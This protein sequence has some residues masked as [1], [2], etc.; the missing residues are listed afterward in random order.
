MEGRKASLTTL[1]STG[2]YNWKIFYQLNW[3]IYIVVSVSGGINIKLLWEMG[4]IY[5]DILYRFQYEKLFCETLFL[6]WFNSKH[7]WII[8]LD[9]YL[10]LNS[11]SN[12]IDEIFSLNNFD[13]QAA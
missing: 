10:I 8:A 4:V 2:K 7:V 6:S 11:F 5:V 1:N 13:M 9:E 12:F 3:L